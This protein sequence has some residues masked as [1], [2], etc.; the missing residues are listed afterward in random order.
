MSE[1]KCERFYE[2]KFASDYREGILE[3]VLGE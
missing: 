3:P 1:D 2:C